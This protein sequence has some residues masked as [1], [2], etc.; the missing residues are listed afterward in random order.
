[1]IA[2]AQTRGCLQKHRD[3]NQ[4]DNDRYGDREDQD[5]SRERFTFCHLVF[6]HFVPPPLLADC[7]LHDAVSGLVPARTFEALAA[8]RAARPR[9]ST[10]SALPHIWPIAT[11]SR[12]AGASRK[13]PPMRSI[14]SAAQ[15]AL[16]VCPAPEHIHRDA[17]RAPA[18]RY[19]VP[20]LRP[21]P[22]VRLSE[23]SPRALGTP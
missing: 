18:R 9:I 16:I 17:S 1:M 13:I 14:D 20:W 11:S 8:K 5:Q 22:T 2:R 7:D 23:R 10:F 19:R 15:A 6:C 21:A 12:E 3:H 4:T